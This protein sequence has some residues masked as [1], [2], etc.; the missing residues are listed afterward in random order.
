MPHNCACPPDGSY[1][2]DRCSE[3]AAQ[4]GISVPRKQDLLRLVPRKQDSSYAKATIQ[5]DLGSFVASAVATAIYQPHYRSKT[6]AR[7]ALYLREQQAEGKIGQF[8]YEPFSLRLGADCHYRPDFLVEIH[9]L[10]CV[11]VKGAWIRDRAMDKVRAAATRYPCFTFTLAQWKDG[12]WTH[13]PIK[14]HI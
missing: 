5:T 14:A 10:H 8:W 11:E 12:V 4:A 13:T 6:E 1:Y 7:Y 9:T 2:C 3:Y